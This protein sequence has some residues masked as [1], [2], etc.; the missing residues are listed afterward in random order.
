MLPIKLGLAVVWFAR[1]VLVDMTAYA[2]W[3]VL[4]LMLVGYIGVII[5]EKSKQK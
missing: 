1:P 4:M 5:Y 3:G 2:L